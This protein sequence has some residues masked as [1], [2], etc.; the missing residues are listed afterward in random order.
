MAVTIEDILM[1]RSLQ[2]QESRIDPATAAALGAASGATVG[3]MANRKKRFAG[4]L[5]GLILGGGLGAGVR[6]QMIAES[7]AARYL[8]KIQVGEDL[9]S[10]ELA[11]LENILTDT[12]SNIVG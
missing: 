1:Q 3:A 12:Y 6:Q 2:D 9:T 4:G 10:Q 11:E 5:T 7:P 8:A